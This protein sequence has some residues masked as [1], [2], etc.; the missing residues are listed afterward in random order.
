MA[1]PQDHAALQNTPRVTPE[2]QKCL[3]L[4]FLPIHCVITVFIYSKKFTKFLYGTLSFYQSFLK[5]YCDPFNVF[6]AIA[7]NIQ[8]FVVQFVCG[9]IVKGNNQKESLFILC[10][11]T[12]IQNSGYQTH[13]SML[14]FC[15]PGVDHNNKKKPVYFS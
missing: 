3:F 6:M 9:V 14:R 11:I 7:I 5:I 4:F 8:H 15:Y 10:N 12:V 2:H 1:T 13:Y